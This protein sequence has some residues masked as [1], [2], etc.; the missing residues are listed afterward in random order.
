MARQISDNEEIHDLAVEA[1]RL[2]LAKFG[3]EHKF[4]TDAIW[5]FV[6]GGVEILSTQKPHQPKRLVKEGFLHDTGIKTKAQSGPRAGSPTTQYGF[7]PT[8]VPTFAAPTATTRSR[9]AEIKAA[10][11]GED[12]NESIRGMQEAMEAE[13]YIISSAELANFI[14]AMTV[15]PLVILSGISGTGKSLLPRKFAKLTKS[16]FHAIPVQPQWADNSD[17]FGYVPTLSNGTFV[18]GK[19]IDSLLAA[20]RDSESMSIAL[21]DEMNL[22]PVEHYF[23][24]FLSVAESRERKDNRVGSDPLPIDLPLAPDPAS[25]A[26]CDELQD[27]ELPHNLR[28][29]GTANMDETTHSFSPKVLDRAFTIEFDDPDLTAFPTSKGGVTTTFESLSLAM[30]DPSNAINIMEARTLNEDLFNR[31][32]AWLE[33]IQGILAPAGIKFGYRT[34]DAILLYLHFWRALGLAGTLAGCAAL[35]FCI[36]QKVLPKI[37]GSGDTLE[38]ALKHL[39]A[40]LEA[41]EERQGEVDGIDGEFAGPLERSRNKVSRMLALLDLDGATRYWGA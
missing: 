21:L 13:G 39:S 11:A 29:V 31:V 19:I 38:R 12:H 26:I 32:A 23:S 3:P 2:M 35:D 17:L 37:S 18:K 24:D 20:S 14:L 40:W 15:S 10:Y 6:P 7:G 9:T 30:I 16:S 25:A 36:L 1:L 22:A 41:W 5:Q 28:I 4:P 8:L 27:I 33:E 34:R